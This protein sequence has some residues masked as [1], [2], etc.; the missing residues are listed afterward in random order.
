MISCNSSNLYTC[1]R[2]KNKNGSPQSF[3][4]M[5]SS[6]KHLIRYNFPLIGY[7]CISA[8][9]I[10][11]LKCHEA[12][13]QPNAGHGKCQ[14][15][16]CIGLAKPVFDNV[17]K[18]WKYSCQ[19][20]AD[21]DECPCN[22]TFKTEKFLIAHLRIVHKI[23][24]ASGKNMRQTIM[25]K[26]EDWKSKHIGNYNASKNDVK[27]EKRF[28]Y[29]YSSVTES[30]IE[31]TL[32]N[33]SIFGK[34]LRYKYG[35]DYKGKP[36]KF[37]EIVHKYQREN[38]TTVEGSAGNDVTNSIS[39]NAKV[40]K[41]DNIDDSNVVS[42]SNDGGKIGIINTTDTSY[43]IGAQDLED[44]QV[45]NS[46]DQSAVLN[47]SLL[48]S[49]P[50]GDSEGISDNYKN[51]ND[52]LIDINNA[53]TGNSIGATEPDN[54]SSNEN[55]GKYC[56][57]NKTPLHESEDSTNSSSTCNKS[58]CNY[59][60]A[61]SRSN[62]TDGKHCGVKRLDVSRFA[63]NANNANKND[64][65]INGNNNGLTNDY[66][67]DGLPIPPPLKRQKL[68]QRDPV[69]INIVNHHVSLLIDFMCE[70]DDLHLCHNYVFVLSL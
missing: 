31:S 4:N 15:T 16:F 57:K 60:T 2:H 20:V 6:N 64:N 65:K 28:R 7:P 63:N 30:K 51:G 43:S 19:Y 47:S 29:I 52:N 24:V 67:S 69:T 49:P 23:Q 39:A 68:V 8:V 18:C 54:Y 25:G 35:A 21:G 48:I 44:N 55:T 50:I 45:E 33:N 17:N 34:I 27:S 66:D 22:K 9:P 12:C 46:S 53:E 32:S 13:L 41:N 59:V 3:A 58:N 37:V 14:W 56:S 40:V 38:N 5:Q 26:T 10:F 36:I 62:R 42:N 11:G 70:L 61:A 1:T